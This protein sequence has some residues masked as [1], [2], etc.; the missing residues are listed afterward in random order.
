MSGEGT[1]RRPALGLMRVG[2]VVV[3]GTSL[4]GESARGSAGP[5][6]DGCVLPS[7]GGSEPF[8][9]GTWAAACAGGC[10]GLSFGITR[11]P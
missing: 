4:F 3:I 11:L 9:L 6:P 5:A 2:G 1:G 10:A 7:G 8:G